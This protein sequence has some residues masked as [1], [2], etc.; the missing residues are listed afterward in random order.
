[1]KAKAKFGNKAFKKV[2][3]QEVETG[4]PQVVSKQ[5]GY[6]R[7]VYHLTETITKTGKGYVLHFSQNHNISNH[8][9]K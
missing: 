2:M 9:K 1:M 4:Y 6:I 7:N 8:A 3:A 5:T